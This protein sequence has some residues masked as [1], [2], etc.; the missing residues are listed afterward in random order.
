MDDIEGKILSNSSIAPG[1]HLLRIRLSRSMG[2]VRPGQFIMVKIPDGEVF[3]RRPFSIYDYQ[4]GILTVM[5]KIVGKGTEQ[6]SKASK[7]TSVLTLGPLGRWFTVDRRNIPVVIAGGIGFAG[8]YSLIKK[9]QGKA[10]IFFGCSSKE[11]IP[12]L[13]DAVRFDPLI[14]TLDGSYGFKGNVV[15]LFKNHLKGLKG[16]NVEIFTCGPV[17][18]VKSIKG[19]IVPHKIPCQVLLEERMACGM[20]LC[21]GCVMK[22]TDAEEPY[23]RVCKEGPV[24]NLW[25]ISL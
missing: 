22:T 19:L 23:K 1:Y 24:F 7:G 17:N 21:F 4:Q 6:L 10:S 2:T 25:E 5:Y 13:R 11:E 18:M 12:L 16:K 3:L 20:G 14:A 9:L 8:I 15:Q